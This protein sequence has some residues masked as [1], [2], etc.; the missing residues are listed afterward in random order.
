MPGAL[1]VLAGALVSVLALL[2]LA[3]LRLEVRVA[4][5]PPAWRVDLGLFGGL[6][7]VRLLDSA[8]P[9]KGRKAPPAQRKAP[10]KARQTTRR[11]RLSRRLVAA[12]PGEAL[13]ALR[14]VRLDHL[15]GEARVGLGDPAETGAFYGRAAALL[16]ALPVSFRLVPLFD[17]AGVEGEG[18]LALSLIPARLLP[19]AAR[20]LWAAR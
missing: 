4:S 8:R 2:L 18:S 13:A 9:R 1:G 7:P 3:P 19:V 6:L 14:A 5:A 11:R 10:R 15:R 20:L 12:L 17:R 16:V